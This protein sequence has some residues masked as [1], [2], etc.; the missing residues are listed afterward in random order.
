[1]KKS[2]AT[3]TMCGKNNT[4]V[5]IIDD[6]TQVCDECLDYAFTQCDICGEYWDDSVI[7]FFCLKDDRLV[8][9]HCAE[10]FDPDDFEEFD[11]E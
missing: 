8:C 6:V 11:E 4:E 2:N 3:C 7:E 1:M 5:T 10:D 9:E